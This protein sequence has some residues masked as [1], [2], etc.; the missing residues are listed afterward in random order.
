MTTPKKNKDNLVQ[1][2]LN[3]DDFREAVEK[4]IIYEK[5]DMSKL[6][7]KALKAYKPFKKVE[8]S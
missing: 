8:K 3:E 4:A 7:R 6:I 1:S 5:G 2:R